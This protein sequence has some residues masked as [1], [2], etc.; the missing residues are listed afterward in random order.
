M[1]NK[2][3]VVVTSGIPLKLSEGYELAIK[4]IDIDGNKVYLELSKDESVVDYKVISPS[5][6]DATDIDKTYYYKNPQVGDQKMLVTIAAHF[7][8]AFRGAESNLATIDGL[9]QISDLPTQVMAD[10]QYDM[11]T[12]RSMDATNGIITMDNKDN[13]ITLIKNKDTTLTG[14][15]KIKTAD[16]YTLR[17]YIYKTVTIGGASPIPAE[18]AAATVNVEPAKEIVTEVNEISAGAEE[19][20][21]V[22]MKAS[23]ALESNDIDAF[24][25]FFTN[26]TVDQ[27]GGEFSIPPEDASNVAEALNNARVVEVYPMIIIYEMEIDERTY[28]FYAMWEGDGWKLSGF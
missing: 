7:K 21:N 28:N 18:N 6:T 16:D 27:I 15:I 1:D 9:W 13:A 3:E 5:K 17:F 14:G 19:S 26:D 2:D 22:V 4:S 12:I 25:K 11:M 10:T 20:K 23:Q 24:N 8:N